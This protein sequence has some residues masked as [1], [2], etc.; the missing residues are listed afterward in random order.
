MFN[1]KKVI[2]LGAGVSGKSAVGLLKCLG[3]KVY[4]Y[5]DDYERAKFCGDECDVSILSAQEF[6][7]VLSSADYCILSP[8][9]SINSNLAVMAQAMGVKVIPEIE[10]GYLVC[11]SQLVAVTGTNGKSSMVRLIGQLFEKN[12]EKIEV[13]G[14]IGYP[15]CDV[16]KA[17][18]CDWTIVEVSSFQLESISDF[19]A[20]ISIILNVK[21]DHIDRHG[22][23]ENYVLAKKNLVKNCSNDDII[24][25][26]C[27]DKYARK[28]GEESDGNV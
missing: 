28:I 7:T 22:G 11:N 19:K 4:I 5:D 9:I 24:I 12:G 25:V 17:N 2:V 1:K 18:N 13:C 8:G 10:L 16:A 15:F 23:F 6:P 26:N 20:G 21:P 3:A 14:N 27:D